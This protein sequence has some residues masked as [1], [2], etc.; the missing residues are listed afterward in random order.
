MFGTENTM[1]VNIKINNIITFINDD[2]NKNIFFIK[3][4]SLLFIEAGN[5]NRIV[6]TILFNGVAKYLYLA[7]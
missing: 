6:I 2:R 1:T 4:Q 7:T 3:N 5:T